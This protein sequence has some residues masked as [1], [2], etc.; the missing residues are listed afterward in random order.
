MNFSTKLH[1][2]LISMTFLRRVMESGPKWPKLLN[3][4]IDLAITSLRMPLSNKAKWF[5]S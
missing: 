2:Q 5:Y 4:D 3:L 1:L